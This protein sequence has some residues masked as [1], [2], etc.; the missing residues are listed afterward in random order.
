MAEEEE[1]NKLA[2]KTQRQRD[3]ERFAKLENKFTEFQEEITDDLSR[4]R[5]EH[6]HMRSYINRLEEIIQRLAGS[7]SW[8]PDI[9]KALDK[10]K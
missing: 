9:K 8:W 1:K 2:T 10:D 6:M 7:K 3:A 5:N 4:F